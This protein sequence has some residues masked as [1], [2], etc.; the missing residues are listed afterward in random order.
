[1]NFFFRFFL[2]KQTK[3]LTKKR[4]ISFLVS[5]L[6][7]YMINLKKEEHKKSRN[8]FFFQKKLKMKVYYFLTFIALFLAFSFVKQNR[9]ESNDVAKV[10]SIKNQTQC[11]AHETCQ[12]KFFELSA[13]CCKYILEHQGQCCHWLKFIFQSE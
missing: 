10:V 1:M 7:F 3:F 6:G 12:V 2:N 8:I 9:C 13:F 11:Q 5:K 4:A